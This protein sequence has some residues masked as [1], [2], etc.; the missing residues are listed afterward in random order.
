VRQDEI[1]T[2]FAD[3]WTVIGIAADT[4]AINPGLG[5]PAAQTWLA[6]IRRR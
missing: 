2:A 3:G 4:L 5:S 6:S 1:G